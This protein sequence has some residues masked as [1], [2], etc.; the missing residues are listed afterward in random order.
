MIRVIVYKPGKPGRVVSVPNSVGMFQ[1]LV[2]GF[3]D[4]FR[5]PETGAYVYFCDEGFSLGL[6]RNRRF[7][8]SEVM[9]TA[10]LSRQDELGNAVGLDD[11]EVRRIIQRYG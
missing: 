5:D 7:G 2:S 3:F 4:V 1:A 11:E 10:V 6:E 8:S 9:G